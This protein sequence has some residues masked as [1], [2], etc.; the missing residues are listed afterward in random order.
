M[1]A[2]ARLL[3]QLLTDKQSEVYDTW[4]RAQYIFA[5]SARR[6]ALAAAASPS[7]RLLVAR[8]TYGAA[9]VVS[10]YVSPCNFIDFY[11]GSSEAEQ[12]DHPAA[13]L[14]PPLD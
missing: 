4:L 10:G 8:V 5:L 1:H 13:S 14:A 12:R 3:Y 7:S 2:L 11:L 9:K 6:R